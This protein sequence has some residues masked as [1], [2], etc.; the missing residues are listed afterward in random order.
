M[1]VA[2]L[3]VALVALAVSTWAAIVAFHQ[4][5]A[6][7]DA[8]GGKGIAFDVAKDS[9][10]VINNRT[11]ANYRVYVELFGPG[12]RYQAELCLSR[13][14]QYVLRSEIEWDEGFEPDHDRKAVTTR[15]VLSCTDEPL[16]WEFSVVPADRASDM[17]CMFTWVDPRADELWT[18][19]YARRLS[20]P[21]VLYEWH[22]YLTRRVRKWLYFWGVAD[23][24]RQRPWHRAAARKRP[25][26]AWR[27]HAPRQLIDRHGPAKN[28]DSIS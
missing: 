11:Q 14:D 10:F 27:E 26:G 19:A 21:G 8:A 24:K 4:L 15:K 3:V 6:G 7:K 20:N 18:G 23:R 9:Q 2:T 25:L 5:R 28:L 13:C 22:W 16:R 12:A 1:D 17:W